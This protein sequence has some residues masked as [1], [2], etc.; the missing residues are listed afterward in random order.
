MDEFDYIVV[1]AGS[2][3]CV[4]ASRLSEDPGASVLLLEAGGSDKR[5]D[6]AM[7][8]AFLKTISDPKLSWGDMGEP[9]PH[10]NGRRIWI[11]RGKVLG[12][13]SSIN[14]M[15]YMRGHPNDFDTW[16]QMGAR[17]WSYDD[18][19]PYFRQMEDSWRGENAY[20]GVGGPLRVEPIQTGHLLH[21]PLRQATLAAGYPATDDINGA[22]AEGPARGEVTI[23][24]RGRRASAA[25]A[26]IRPALG[27]KNLDVRLKAMARRILFDGNR[28]VGIEYSVD[29]ETR[30][31][32]ARRE[33]IL[34]GGVY[35]SPQLLM[36][37]GVGPAAHLSE[38]GISVK[39]DVPGVGR[40]ISE[41]PCCMMEFAAAKP[42][43]F[44]NELRLDRATRHFFQWLL[45]GT[46]KFATQLNSCNVILRTDPALAQPDIQ[47]MSNPVTFGARLWMPPFRPRPDHKLA[48]GVVVLNQR[49]RGWMTLRSTDPNDRPAITLN[50]MDDP[51]DMQTMIRGIREARRIYRTAPQAALTG[52][53]L[54]PGDQ[55]Q[56]DDE[57]EDWV[58]QVVEIGQHAVGSCTMG[59][60]PDA[61]VDPAL[62][63]KGVTGLRVIDASVMPT[64]PGANT[65]ATVIMIGEKGADLVK[66]EA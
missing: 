3:G 9:E 11:P 40:N 26:Y 59:T 24:K 19:L 63:V 17:G 46:G 30:Q 58:R 20:H 21:E 50:I 4:V 61:V 16:A 2:A 48:C 37:S 23:D 12:G 55:V 31:V 22:D 56:S 64:V 54:M 47:L 57:M 32:R 65:N 35:N 39:A 62:R 6:I 13:S 45:F 27:R 25:A 8:L 15:F 42:V 43:T 1:G 53:E 14:G 52:T 28:A 51:W 10:L 7:P 60:G 66:A 33:V 44:V 36:L 49:S 41:H 34:S 38:M 5:L 18:V 29:G